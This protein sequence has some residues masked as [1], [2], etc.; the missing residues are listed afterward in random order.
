MKFGAM[1][2]PLKPIIEEIKFIGKS[3]F[4]FIELT[5]EAPLTIKKLLQNKKKIMNILSS[6]K[7]EIMA[8]APCFVYTADF[9]ES[10]RKASQKEILDSLDLVHDFGIKKVVIHPSYIHGLGKHL[11]EKGK[12]EVKKIGYEFLSKLYEK[13][14]GLDII[15][16]LENMMP[17]GRWLFDPEEFKPI[18]KDF[19]KMKLTLDI[20]HANITGK[21]ISL[22]FIE[23]FGKRIGHIHISDNFGL[24]DNHLPLGCGR[25]HFE[26][27]FSALKKTGYNDSMT[28]EI[29]SKDTDYLVLSLKKA[30][31]I[32]KKV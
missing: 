22:R 15:L 32:W 10:I 26:K 27:I 29:F 6:Y 17:E 1:N 16:C 7:L 13:A 8:H 12:E 9:Y 31:E 25:I 19:K 21:N 11:D 28:L 18:L 2:N 30:R 5:V 24:R 4:D 14:N 23:L 3:D 20:G